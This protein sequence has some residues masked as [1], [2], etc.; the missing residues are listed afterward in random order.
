M[1]HLLQDSFKMA[2]DLLLASLKI[3]GYF[4]EQNNGSKFRKSAQKFYSYCLTFY[5]IT[6]L[7]L[8]YVDLYSDVGYENI[9]IF[10]ILYF[11]F[12]TSF[13]LNLLAIQTKTKELSNLEYK[14]NLLLR[15]TNVFS[16]RKYFIVFFWGFC[17]S[18]NVLK[19]KRFV[20]N[21][22]FEVALLKNI[23]H[24]YF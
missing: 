10:Y 3:C 12:F 14:L 2:F 21:N 23:V 7:L 6:M 5:R 15:N 9:S 4:I 13:V 24:N 17:T 11:V 1:Q 8:F 22:H 18:G 16:N 19:I 20:A